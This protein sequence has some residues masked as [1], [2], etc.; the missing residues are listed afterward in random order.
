MALKTDYKEDVFE[1]SRKYQVTQDTDG[2]TEI[3]DVTT[4]SQEGDSFGA[5]DI[6]ATN[7]AVN[8][9]AAAPLPATLTVAG[10]TGTA[11]PYTQTV[12]AEGITAADNPM[13]VSL[14]ADDAT[15]DVQKAYN[16]AFGIVASGT[17]VTG[18]G[19][20]TF[21]VYKLPATDIVVGLKGV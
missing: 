21:K 18:D 3:S 5:A 6:N 4:Y 1:G 17:A 7:A 2:N 14:L 19:T 13:L 10:W 16:K 15:A 8:R 9:I 20:V 11:A 12:A